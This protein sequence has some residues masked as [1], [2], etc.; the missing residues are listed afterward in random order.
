MLI[1]KSKLNRKFVTNVSHLNVE[2][3][4]IVSSVKQVTSFLLTAMHKLTLTLLQTTL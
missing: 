3:A 4:N 2:L 1:N